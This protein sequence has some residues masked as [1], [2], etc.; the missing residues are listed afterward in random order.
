MLLQNLLLEELKN[1][2]ENKKDILKQKYNA[3]KKNK[4]KEKGKIIYKWNPN[5]KLKLNQNQNNHH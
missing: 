4:G 3:Y 1:I 5:P 2:K